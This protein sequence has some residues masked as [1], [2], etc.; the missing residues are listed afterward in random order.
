QVRAGIARAIRLGRVPA[1]ERL[2]TVRELAADLGVAVNTVAK[3]YRKLESDGLVAGRGRR[4][5]FVVDVLPVPPEEA[6]LRLAVA[7]RAYVRRAR[8][9]GADDR[10][11]LRA[12]RRAL[13]RD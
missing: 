11:A 6:E 5:T 12:A 8:Q 2:P 3:A 4:G 9:L 7:A 10:T 1:G 13:K